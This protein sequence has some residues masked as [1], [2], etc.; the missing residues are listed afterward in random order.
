[1]FIITKKCF[2]P[3]SSLDLYSGLRWGHTPRFERPLTG[4]LLKG[5]LPREVPITHRDGVWRC[6]ELNPDLRKH[7]Y[8]GLVRYRIFF[9]HAWSRRISKPP[10]TANY[11]LSDPY[12]IGNDS[13]HIPV[14]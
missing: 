4:C 5:G 14:G 8:K 1:M 10:Q 12:P 3:T 7:V 11:N 13:S 2:C 9:T 6:R